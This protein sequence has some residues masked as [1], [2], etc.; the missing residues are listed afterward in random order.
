M[1]VVLL[2]RFLPR[3]AL[4]LGRE[5]DLAQYPRVVVL[6]G[7]S[8]L[9]APRSLHDLR[10]FQRVQQNHLV[11]RLGVARLVVAAALPARRRLPELP[12]AL[13]ELPQVSLP[14][15]VWHQPREVH[16]TKRLLLS[17]RQAPV[18]PRSARSVLHRVMHH[19]ARRDGDV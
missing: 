10:D 8:P 16:P 9:L 13:Y 15:V 4:A 19:E 17:L 6:H 12:R 2:V 5:L 11:V 14:R 3:L 18:L 1:H 7:P